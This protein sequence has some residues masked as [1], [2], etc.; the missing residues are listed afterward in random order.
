MRSWERSN[1]ET[2]VLAQIDV[3]ARGRFSFPAEIDCSA[4]RPGRPCRNWHDTWFTE[5]IEHLLDLGLTED[6]FDL[7]SL[8]EQ[9]QLPQTTA[10][11]L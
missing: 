9:H 10:H 1:A 5:P 7:T 6:E 8:F 4:R 11:G 2:A 3:G